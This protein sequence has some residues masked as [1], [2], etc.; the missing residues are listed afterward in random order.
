ML[1]PHHI[2][3]TWW[4]GKILQVD[5][6]TLAIQVHGCLFLIFF[7]RWS[8]G[9]FYY[10][11]LSLR[12]FYSWFDFLWYAVLGSDVRFFKSLKNALVWRPRKIIEVL[13][14]TDSAVL[15]HDRRLVGRKS[16]QLTQRSKS[17][18]LRDLSCKTSERL[19]IVLLL[20][21]VSNT[22]VFLCLQILIV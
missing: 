16:V 11:L 8:G 15:T 5:V 7:L 10:F 20:S 21:L 13:M 2:C 17:K 1:Q 4:F 14:G 9:D 3:A 12:T 6:E 19:C 22:T 18:K